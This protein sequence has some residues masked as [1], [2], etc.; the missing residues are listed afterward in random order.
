MGVGVHRIC[1][2]VCV[3]HSTGCS[4]W[5][6]PAL[7]DWPVVTDIVVN[8]LCVRAGARRVYVLLAAG[9]SSLAKDTQ[10]N[11]TCQVC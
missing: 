4:L 2:S 8:A 10:L 6:H 11:K 3:A 1:V 9:S 7:F 5:A